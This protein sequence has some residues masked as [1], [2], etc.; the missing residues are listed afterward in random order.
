MKI[1]E[2]SDPP[3]LR[4]LLS[5]TPTLSYCVISTSLTK[6]A[7]SVR[8]GFSTGLDQ[9]SVA[10]YLVFCSPSDVP[11]GTI[12]ELKYDR[13][14]KLLRLTTGGEEYCRQDLDFLNE[15]Q[16]TLPGGGALRSTVVAQLVIK[17]PPTVDAT[18]SLPVRLPVQDCGTHPADVHRR[19]NCILS[20]LPKDVL[21]E[22]ISWLP[23]DAFQNCE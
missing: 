15:E 22:V 1:V 20:F 16:D 8:M 13:Q 21:F 11:E 6:W 9:E 4:V 7:G 17:V 5:L 3:P 23:S 14:N 18:D 10:R 2:L 12:A 19:E